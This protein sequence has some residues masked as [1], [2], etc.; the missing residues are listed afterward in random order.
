[1]T[2]NV[3]GSDGRM[4]LENQVGNLRFD[5]TIGQTKAVI[6]TDSGMNLVMGQDGQTHAETQI[7]QMRQTIGKPGFDLLL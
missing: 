1:M 4:H 6:P 7:G 5:P 3:I 2:R